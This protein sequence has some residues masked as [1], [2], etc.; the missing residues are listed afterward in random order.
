[1]VISNPAYNE[2]GQAVEVVYDRYDSDYEAEQP[3]Q[4]PTPC[5]PKESCNKTGWL[6]NIIFEI[7]KIETVLYQK[8]LND[9][10]LIRTYI[11]EDIDTVVPERLTHLRYPQNPENVSIFPEKKLNHEK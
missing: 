11:F 4:E 10:E 3:G 9:L 2:A 1:M 8:S 7:W 6:S 5:T